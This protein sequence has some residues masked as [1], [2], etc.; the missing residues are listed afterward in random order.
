MLKLRFSQRN[1]HEEVREQFQI[2]SIDDKLRNRL[3]SIVFNLFES[4]EDNWNHSNITQRAQVCKVVW[5]DFYALPV[6]EIPQLTR[7]DAVFC[8][9]AIMEFKGQFWKSKWYQKYDFIEYICELSEKGLRTNLDDKFN[10]ALEKERGGY[11][12]INGKVSAITNETEIAEISELLKGKKSAI[13][14]HIETALKHLN[15]RNNPDYRNSIKESISAVESFCCQIV[16]KDT[17]TLG[18]AL[19]EID[20]KWPIHGALKNGFSA[21]YGYTSDADGIRHK[22]L[23]G[24]SEPTF[25]DAKF[26][27][28]ICSAFINY[29]KSKTV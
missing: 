10:D 14:Q 25:D 13:S 27:L 26:F 7:S 18:E 28:V 16:N 1:K 11:R 19:K 6:D 17:A 20:K 15:D 22:L 2:D 9:N 5:E 21:I 3:W 12:V 23:E 24:E 29:L 4:L 8:H